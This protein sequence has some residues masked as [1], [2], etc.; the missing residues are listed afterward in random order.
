MQ[1]SSLAH[2]LGSNS[3]EQRDASGPYVIPMVPPN[4]TGDLH[5]GHALMVSVQDAIARLHRQRGRQVVYV[6]GVDH[7]G[8][9]MHALVIRNAN[10]EP[11]LPL[12][13]RLRDWAA[14]NRRI[15][16]S[17]LRALELSCDWRRETYTLSR[18]YVRLVHDTFRSLA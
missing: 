6:P 8:L 2:A 10:F 9:A 4:L 17:Q 3:I 12:S 5:L 7:A 18:S 14:Q 16:R 15:I 13:R 11:G 1:I